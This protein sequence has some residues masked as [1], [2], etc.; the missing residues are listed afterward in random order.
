M[1]R[2]IWIFS[3]LLMVTGAVAQNKPKTVTSPATKKANPAPLMKT[4][5]DTLSYSL[6]QSVGGQLKAIDV[7]DLNYLLFRKGVEDLLKGLPSVLTQQQISVALNEQFTKQNEKQISETKEKGKRFLA[8]NKKRPGVFTLPNGLQYEIL[9][10]GSGASPKL[11]DTI[12]AN[13]VGWVIEGKEFDN[14][15]K[16]GQPLKIQVNNLIKGWT[17]ALIRMTAGSKWKLYI[18]SELGYGDYGTPDGTI[19]GGAT[20]VFEMELL[21]VIPDKTAKTNNQ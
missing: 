15:Y 9:K 6:G 19:P 21:E 10:E 4:K 5:L 18:P 17:E 8:E 3:L 13:Y 1:K 11:T 16:R 7:N 12:V 20:L 14:S 2:F